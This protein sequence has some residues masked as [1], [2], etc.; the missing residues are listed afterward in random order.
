M[1]RV[2]SQ[3]TEQEDY[4]NDLGGG[5]DFRNW[6]TAHLLIFDGFGDPHGTVG[7]HLAYANILQ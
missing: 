6:A 5:I 1:D 3:A 4:S 2:I 7:C